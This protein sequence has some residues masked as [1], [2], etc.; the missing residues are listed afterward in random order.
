LGYDEL[1]GD[2]LR[3]F[4]GIPNIIRPMVEPKRPRSP[5]AT[6]AVC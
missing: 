6:P 5:P 1:R 2:F 4:N 3:E